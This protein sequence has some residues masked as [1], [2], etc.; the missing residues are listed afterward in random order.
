MYW[1]RQKVSLAHPPP[2]LDRFVLGYYFYLCL[3]SS[4]ERSEV[5]HHQLV[6][7]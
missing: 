2:L 7:L 4:L 3:C 6:S 5:R 1:H